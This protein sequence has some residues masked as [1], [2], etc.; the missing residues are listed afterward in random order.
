MTTRSRDPS[1]IRAVA[2]RVRS[3]DDTS[4]RYAKVL[5]FGRNKQGKTRFAASGPDVLIVDTNEHGTTSA[6]G[7]GA[8]VI[9]AESFADIADVYWWMASGKHKYKTVAIDGLPGMHRMSMDMV[10]DEAERRS[11]DRPSKQADK[12]DWGRAGALMG[13]MLLAYRN[14]PMHV[15]FT[16]TERRIMDDDTGELKMLTLDLPAG[17]RGVALGA[18]DIIGYME[19]KKVKQRRNGKIVR[20]FT[21]TMKV[22]PDE[23]L[24]TGDRTNNLGDI[25]I[26]PTMSKVIAAYGGNTNEED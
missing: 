9:E 2:R 13:G 4:D 17:V 15:V 1:R 19:I 8:R 16:C 21:D 3:V 10:T 14:L 6:A 11:P 18:V 24:P 12:R 26:R 5:A 22:G 20:A 23:V 25:I 7:S